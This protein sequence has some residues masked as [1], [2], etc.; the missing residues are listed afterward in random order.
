MCKRI[1]YFISISCRFRFRESVEKPGTHTVKISEMA[2][3]MPSTSVYS[4]ITLNC[5]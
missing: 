4:K 5:R 3:I 1:V 2:E